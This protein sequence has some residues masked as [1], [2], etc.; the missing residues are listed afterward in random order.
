MTTTLLEP[1]KRIMRWTCDRFHTA[2]DA[3]AFEGQNVLLHHGEIL[4]IPAPN[5]PHNSGLELTSTA[6]REALG[7]GYWVRTQMALALMVDYDPVPDV[8][9]IVGSPRTVKVQPTTALLVVEVA[10]STLAFDLSTKATLY[11]TVKIQEYWVLDLKGRELVVH[12]EP[13]LNDDGDPMY[14][15]VVKLDAGGIVNPL[16]MPEATIN[17]SDLLP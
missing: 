5:P 11:A 7:A 8:A 13:G 6:L 17:I 16:M 4:E 9:V 3:G 15:T 14:L 2:F 1:P 12:R 10:D